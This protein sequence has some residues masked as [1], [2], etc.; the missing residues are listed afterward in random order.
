[1]R[2]AKEQGGITGYAHSASGLEIDPEH[3]ARR[4]VAAADRDS[5]GQLTPDE[6]RAALLP[7]SFAA[8][9][10]DSDGR[11]SERE[12][13]QR[14]DRVADELPNL[15]VPEMNGVGAMEIC[16]STAEGVCDFISAMDTSRIPEWNCWYHILNC[17]FPLKVSG[18]TDFP[19]MS[20]RSVGQGRV[21][22]ELGRPRRVDFA[23]WCRRL[24]EGRSYVS[25][26][27]AHAVDFEVAGTRSGHGDVPLA[28]PGQITAKARVAFAPEMPKAVAYASAPSARGARDIGDTVLLHG[29][30]L[31]EMEVGGER[32]VELVVNGVAIAR[33]RVAADGALHDVE[34]KFPIERSSWVALRQFPQ[35]HT[36]PVNV[37]VDNKPIRASRR[38]ALWCVAA[39]ELLWHNREKNIT[40]PERAAAEQAFKKAIERYRKIAEECPPET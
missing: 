36:N 7:G 9:D 15:A 14:L 2:W 23:E 3:A 10:A 21:Y 13:M 30:R 1:M 24:A 39:T 40:A 19:C 12:L 5:D 8:I 32:L 4:I 11:L 16:V 34:F 6:A 22:V 25:D 31:E 29:P 26:G 35:L 17:G 33:Q 38:S 18:E 37:I 28:Q 27:Y 20:S